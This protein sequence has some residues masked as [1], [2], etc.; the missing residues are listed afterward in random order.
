[1]TAIS[2]LRMLLIL[3]PFVIAYLVK[4][5]YKGFSEKGVLIVT[6]GFVLW[7]IL[8]PLARMEITGFATLQ[9][10]GQAER[11]ERGFKD[12]AKD[13]LGIQTPRRITEMPQMISEEGTIAFW[14][15]AGHVE[16]R[17]VFGRKYLIDLRSEEERNRLSFFFESIKGSNYLVLEI[18]S[19]DGK[20]YSARVIV[21]EW[22]DGSRHHI[23]TTWS[24]ETREI[25]LYLGGR[26]ESL[27]KA[28]GD[29]F[30]Q[31]GATAL[32]Y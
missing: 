3:I 21:D 15:I 28:E 27:M 18:Y 30:R 24:N 23:T 31:E 16:G 5:Y 22:K 17:T 7:S 32:L 14:F 20:K 9:A 2:F 25:K 4:D 12:F 19:H 8:I 10:P 26:L 29:I 13:I 6:T 11:R 1:M